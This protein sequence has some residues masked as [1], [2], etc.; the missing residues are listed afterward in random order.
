MTRSIGI[1]GEVRMDAAL[2]LTALCVLVSPAWAAAAEPVSSAARTMLVV[3]LYDGAALATRDIREASRVA[4]AILAAGGVDVRWKSCPRSRSGPDTQGCRLPLAANEAVLRLIP[5]STSMNSEPAP[6]GFTLLD[7]RGR[8]PVLST[9]FMNRVQA[10][11][12][13]ARVDVPLLTGRAMAHELGHL[14][15]ATSGHAD[16]GLMRAFWSD[17]NLRSRSDADWHLQPGEVDAIRRGRTQPPA[18]DV[19]GGS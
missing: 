11:A 10:V 18:F 16:T 15:L 8:Q 19:T 17:D 13:R 6:L 1:G 7:R 3:R 4:A 14:L 12:S 2:L 9:V 5:A